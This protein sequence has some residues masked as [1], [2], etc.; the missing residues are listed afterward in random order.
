MNSDDDVSQKTTSTYGMTD[1]EDRDRSEWEGWD[2]ET[3]SLQQQQRELERLHELPTESTPREQALARVRDALAAVEQ[4]PV[5]GVD[6][7]KA[8]TIRAVAGDLEAIETALTHEVAQQR[9]DDDA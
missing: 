9:E 4:V 1:D 6:A 2:G 7:Q 5:A 8:A 3:G